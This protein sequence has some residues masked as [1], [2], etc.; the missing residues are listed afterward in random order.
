MFSPKP[1]SSFSLRRNMCPLALVTAILGLT[2]TSAAQGQSFSVLHSFTGAGDG[3]YPNGMAIDQAGNLYGASRQSGGFGQGLIFKMANG[4][5]GWTL[6]PLHVF[7]IP[8]TDGIGPNGVVVGPD[9]RLYGT[10]EGGGLWGY[11]TVF[12]LFPPVSPCRTVF[13]P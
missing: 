3:S 1:T 8:H 4:P 5:S 2:L 12:S 9:G 11:G 7:G 10:T 6:V 13:C